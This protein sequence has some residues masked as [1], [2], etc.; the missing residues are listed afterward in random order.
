M[1]LD[2]AVQGCGLEAK[3]WQAQLNSGS[4]RKPCNDGYI[5]SIRGNELG[6][7]IREAAVEAC[8]WH[9]LLLQVAPV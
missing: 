1:V 3:E 8:R 9:K 5:R 2:F 4:E 6:R 7:W